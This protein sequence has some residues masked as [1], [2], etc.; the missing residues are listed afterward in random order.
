MLKEALFLSQWGYDL[1]LDEHVAVFLHHRGAALAQQLGHFLAALGTIFS[2]FFSV[3]VVRG[4]FNLYVQRPWV[5][6]WLWG[7]PV[8]LWQKICTLY[9]ICRIFAHY[10]VTI[11]F[12]F[13]SPFLI[14]VIVHK[15]TMHVTKTHL[16][17]QAP[18]LPAVSGCHRQVG[19]VT[20]ERERRRLRGA[21]GPARP[22]VPG[23]EPA[24]WKGGCGVE[25][26]EPDGSISS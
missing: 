7:K 26:Q 4:Y 5:R 1:H 15:V 24:T 18:R 11:F 8:S 23:P 16:Q 6:Q 20:A 10:C 3:K 2:L 14:F 9:P 21:P 19:R 22:A 17:A 13:I 25:W 12:K